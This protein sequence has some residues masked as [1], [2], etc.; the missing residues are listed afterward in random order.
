[1]YYKNMMYHI[2]SIVLTTVFLISSTYYWFFVREVTYYQEIVNDNIVANEIEF[3]T[4][5]KVSDKDIV[6]LDGYV[7]KIQNNGN[8]KEDIEVYI[9]P[10]L[11]FNNVSNNYIKYQIN[12]G[13]I[14]SL[15]SDGM[16]YVSHLNCLEEED[17]NLKIWLSETYMGDLNYNGRVIVS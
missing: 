12:D 17:I 5:N 2:T 13:N 16:I 14:R 4:L 6:M 1:M 10:N 9:I 3:I 11:L 7:L 8:E 15:N